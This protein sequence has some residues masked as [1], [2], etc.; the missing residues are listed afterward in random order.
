MSGALEGRVV[1]V[2][3]A[4]RGIGRA[5]ALACA[6][7]GASVVVNDLGCDPSGVGQDAEPAE[8]VAE[9]IR[10]AGGV[11][12]SDGSDVSDPDACTRLLTSTVETLGRVDAVIAAAGIVADKTLLKTDD[13]TL[14]R[15][16][17]LHITGTYA[18]VRGSARCMVDQGDGGA[19][20]LHTGP[21][22][23]FGARAQSALA[24]V[25]GGTVGLVRSAALELRRHAIRVNAIAPTAR[26]RTTESLPLFKGIGPDS[27]G[28]DFVGPVGAFL[29]SD[30]ARDVSGEIVG[31]AGTRLYTLQGRETPGWFGAGAPPSVNEVAAAWA[32]VTRP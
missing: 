19:I 13:A 4:G 32:E 6:A 1:L 29:A 5:H 24:S 21:V 2:T 8:N 9:A 27:M 25:M 30:A 7:E 16:V 18:L 12:V 10:Q 14:A 15:L 28:P 31:V 3:G 26:T 11:A 23:L 22:G 20:V 17:A